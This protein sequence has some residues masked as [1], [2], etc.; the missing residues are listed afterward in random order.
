MIARVTHLYIRKDRIDEVKR[1]FEETVAADV[2]PRPGFKHGYLLT[3]QTTGHCITFA[4]WEDAKGVQE[5]EKSGRFQ[6]R[7]NDLKDISTAPVVR[8]IYEVA[9]V[10]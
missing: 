8:E 3:D 4:L 9:S 5:D 6:A 7:V 10:I 1:Y 2:T